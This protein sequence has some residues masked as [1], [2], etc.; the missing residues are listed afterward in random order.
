MSDAYKM[1]RFFLIYMFAS[2]G[3][4]DLFYSEYAGVIYVS[5]GL[6]FVIPKRSKVIP[7]WF[8]AFIMRSIFGRC[9]LFMA[10][11]PQR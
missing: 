6:D 3:F 8:V 1:H 7:I 11:V 2:L 4:S 10:R 9:L 5:D